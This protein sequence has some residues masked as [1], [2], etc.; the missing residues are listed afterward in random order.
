MSHTQRVRRLLAI[1]AVLSCSASMACKSGDPL[2]ADT[3]PATAAFDADTV[4]PAVQER[5]VAFRAGSIEGGRIT[6]DVVVTEVGDPVAGLALRLAY[7]ASFARFV[8]CL[9]G[10]LLPAGAC[11]SSEPATGQLL[12]GRSVTGS[13]QAT[14]VSGSRVMVRLEFLVFGVG[15]CT[16]PAACRIRIEGQNLGGSDASALLGITGDPIVVQWFSGVLRGE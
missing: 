5:Y 10:D 11:L 15:D 3:A 13:G 4:P 16:D 1:V 8:R 12:I 7:P 2:S 6:L 14:V 9:D